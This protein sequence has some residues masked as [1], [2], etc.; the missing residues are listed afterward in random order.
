MTHNDLIIY[1]AIVKGTGGYEC[2]GTYD[3]T[4]SIIRSDPPSA[5]N[6]GLTFRSV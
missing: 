2:R 3:D 6:D 4:L 5:N 1:L